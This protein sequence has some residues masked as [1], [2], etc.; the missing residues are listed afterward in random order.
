MKDKRFQ[1][2]QINLK[3]EEIKSTGNDQ[4][5]QSKTL[6]EYHNQLETINYYYDYDQPISTSESN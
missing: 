4:Q 1:V 3:D 5:L 6:I 2:N